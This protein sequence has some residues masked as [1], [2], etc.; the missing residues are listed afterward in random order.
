METQ[1]IKLYVLAGLKKI[2]RPIGSVP[3]ARNLYPIL[4]EFL[5][6]HGEVIVN[7]KDLWNFKMYLNVTDVGLS[8]ML[9][10]NGEYEKHETILL[11]NLIKKGDVFLDVGANFGY[12]TLLA[13][14]LVGKTGK[15]FSFEPDPYNF[16]ILQRNIKI[17]NCANVLCVNKAVG[18]RDEKIYF[19]ID[20]DNLGRHNIISNWSNHKLSVD[21]ISLDNFFQKGI[22]VDLVKIDIEGVEELAISGMKKIIQTNKQ[23]K[24]LIEFFPER[25]RQN[26]LNPNNLNKLINSFGFSIY[27]VRQSGITKT[28]FNEVLK[29]TRG[30]GELMNI[31]LKM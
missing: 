7:I 3:L 20:A 8:H 26:K 18:E 21:K 14:K 5:K 17:N 16:S 11:K 2:L 29:R 30:K 13:S 22:R 10:L 15:V 31:L 9:L 27:E 12:Y 25:I 1:I 4:S 19:Y 28:S 23:I 6:N 24:L